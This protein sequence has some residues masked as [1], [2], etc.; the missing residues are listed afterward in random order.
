MTDTTTYAQSF[1]NPAIQEKLRALRA[2]CGEFYF[3]IN[4]IS[5]Y[6][7]AVPSEAAYS[8]Q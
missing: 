3:S 2:L 1:D 7:Y 8:L 5:E 6:L 4:S